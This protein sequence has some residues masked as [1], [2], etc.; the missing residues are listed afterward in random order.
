MLTN[1]TR[2]LEGRA[3]G[4]VSHILLTLLDLDLPRAAISRRPCLALQRSY[5]LRASSFAHGCQEQCRSSDC[6]VVRALTVEI[7]KLSLPYFLI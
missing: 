4:L 6:N 3:G 1:Q 7:L 2:T 5:R